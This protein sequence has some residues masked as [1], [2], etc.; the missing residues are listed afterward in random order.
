MHERSREI[1]IPKGIS[2]MLA[3]TMT[4]CQGHDICTLA[5]RTKQHFAVILRLSSSKNRHISAAMGATVHSPYVHL[6]SDVHE[7]RAVGLL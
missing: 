3:M 4:Q 5:Y 2:V 6:T 7:K 1:V